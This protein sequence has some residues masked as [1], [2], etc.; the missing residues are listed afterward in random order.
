MSKKHLTFAVSLIVSCVLI[1][2]LFWNVEWEK[3]WQ[4][5][6]TVSYPR[7]IP[8]VIC[9]ALAFP[10]RALRLKYLLPKSDLSFSTLHA[11]NAVGILASVMLPF[12][13]GEFVRPA[14]LQKTG[15]ISFTG[16][17]AS[18]VTE[19]IFDIL[20]LLV[21]FS[22]ALGGRANLPELAERGVQVLV[23]LVSCAGL[24]VLL[25]YFKANLIL[26]SAQ[27]VLKFAPLGLRSKLLKLVED[28][29]QGLGGVGSLRALIAAILLSLVIWVLYSIKYYFGFSAFDAQAPLG[30]G[31][32]LSS[33]IGIAVAVPAAP[34]FVGTYQ[35][36][37]VAAVSG[38]YGY[39]REIALGFAILTHVL[40]LCVLVMVGGAEYFR[41]R[42]LNLGKNQ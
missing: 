21:V 5:I 38:I 28:F 13:A 12:R 33:M 19:R 27:T 16:A 18:S 42:K 23:V 6:G 34:G 37:S 2:A 40:E 31:F 10:L 7:L 35:A 32:A 14:L 1:V 17:L 22:I 30:T 25:G 26:K 4:V 36:G 9:G 11:A 24:F 20:A 15:R 39:N 41:S 3:F 29:L 8:F